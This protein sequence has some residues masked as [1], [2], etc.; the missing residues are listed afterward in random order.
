MTECKQETFAFTE[1]FSRSVEAAFTSVRVPSDGG[2]VLLREADRR[3]NL[4][5]RLA[6]CFTDGRDAD[7]VE[8]SIAQMLAQRIYGLALGYEDLCDHDQLR[9]DPLFGVLA[10]KRELGQPLA[11][12]P[13][14]PRTGLRPWGGTATTITTAIFRCISSPATSYCARGCVRPIRM[15]RRAQWKK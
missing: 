14:P 13:G 4:M 11:G 6:A 5:G 8:H 12:K 2:V 15:R 9:T 1:R 7:R 10:G 3:I